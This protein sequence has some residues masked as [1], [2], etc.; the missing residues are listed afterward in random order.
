MSV[1]DVMSMPK[2]I[3]NNKGR[4]VSAVWSVWF[5]PCVVPGSLSLENRLL[6]PYFVSAVV[7]FVFVW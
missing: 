4:I 7:H 1:M 2:S 5:P 3:P 6:L